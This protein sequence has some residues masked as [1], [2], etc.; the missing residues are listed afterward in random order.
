MY[1]SYLSIV[2][3]FFLLLKRRWYECSCGF[4]LL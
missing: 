1:F 2:N 4:Y 3:F